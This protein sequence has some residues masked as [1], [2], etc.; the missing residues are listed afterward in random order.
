[1]ERLPDRHTDHLVIGS[2]IA[3]L[4]LA[5][6]LAQREKVVL[7]AKR[8]L[9]ENAT[10]YAQGGIASAIAKDDSI[11]EHVRDTLAAGAGLCRADVVRKVV[12]AGPQGIEELVK[13]GVDFTK[14][15]EEGLNFH[16]TKEG[17]HSRR[18]VLHAHDTTGKEIIRALVQQLRKNPNI[19]VL[20]DQIAVDLLTTDKYAPDFRA[21]YCLGA[22]VM[23]RSSKQVYL[24]RSK[25]TYLCTGG[26]GKIYLYT[27][28]PD[29]ATGDGLAMGWRAGCK[30]A[31]LEFMQFHPTCLYEPSAKTFLISEAVRGEGGIIRNRKGED[32]TK[33]FDP[34]GS[35]APRDIVARAIDMELKRSGEPHV[36]LDVRHLGADRI[37]QMFPNIF[38]TCMHYGFDMATMM[39]PIVPAAH[40]SCGGLIVDDAGRTNVKNLYALGEVAC[41]GLHGANRLAS[42]SLLE[43]VVFSEFVANDAVAGKDEP[44]F[45]DVA[46]PSWNSGRAVPPDELVV[47]THIWDEIRRLM[48]NY[49][50]IIRSDRR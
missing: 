8:Q 24:V 20:E 50:G 44:D 37:K 36:F 31:N 3:G 41:T 6:K 14:G 17:G 39:L 7:I 49:V 43:A 10:R 4:M 32:F 35:L 48:W 33:N 47:L 22:Y 12:E 26:H 42:N 30:V 9:D 40:Y 34:R 16:L 11:E 21:N 28:N 2:G 38:E 25:R 46:V 15:D 27:S 23:D 18:R 1:M 45:S 5:L 13:L 19:S 29:S